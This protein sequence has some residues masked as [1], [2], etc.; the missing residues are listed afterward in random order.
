MSTRGLTGV[1]VKNKNYLS[2]SHCDS[3]PSFMLK[4]MA[5]L[6]VFLKKRNLLAKLGKKVALLKK[7]KEYK[8]CSDKEFEKY[9]KYC[10]D[11]LGHKSKEYYNLLR[12]LQGTGWIKEIA[13]GNLNIYINDNYFITDIFSCRWAYIINL[14]THKL[15]IY[16]NGRK[17]IKELDLNSVDTTS[18]QTLITE[19][20]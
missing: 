20:E 11:L 2:Y 15:E 19:L 18:I 16:K 10:G 14:D 8:E 3:Y 5:E 6:I 1:R 13:L 4:E 12:S 7:V 17:K 9:S